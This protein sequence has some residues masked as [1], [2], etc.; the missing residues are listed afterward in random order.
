MLLVI[1]RRTAHRCAV[2]EYVNIRLPIAGDCL[3]TPSIKV[4]QI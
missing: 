4:S 2:L 3:V 1:P